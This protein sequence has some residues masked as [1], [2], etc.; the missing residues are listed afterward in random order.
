MIKEVMT[1]CFI[2]TNI[3]D[4]CCSSNDGRRSHHSFACKVGFDHSLKS[5]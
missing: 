1:L 3:Y 2:E 4:A 5:N